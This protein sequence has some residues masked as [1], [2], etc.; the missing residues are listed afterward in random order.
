MCNNE[1]I[2][3]DVWYAKKCMEIRNILNIYSHKEAKVIYEKK[4]KNT[5]KWMFE[6]NE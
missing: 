5:T 3:Y 2:I 1:Q 6:N 4:A